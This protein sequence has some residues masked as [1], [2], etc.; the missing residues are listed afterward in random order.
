MFRFLKKQSCSSI[1]IF[2]WPIC[3]RTLTFALKNVAC[4]T[5]RFQSLHLYFIQPLFYFL[6]KNFLGHH[7]P[8]SD[9]VFSTYI[10]HCKLR[11]ISINYRPICPVQL[12][13]IWGKR[14]LQYARWMIP[15]YS[16]IYVC[17]VY[18]VHSTQEFPS[19]DIL[20]LGPT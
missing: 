1:V 9:G 11:F 6:T 10:V 2:F 7:G 18:R 16:A 20:L 17:G 13:N 8:S 15:F 5:K 3:S 12:Q 4:S 14:G 19:F